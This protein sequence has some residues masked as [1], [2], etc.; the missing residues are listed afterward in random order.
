MKLKLYRMNEIM[1]KLLKF[2]VGLA[3]VLLLVSCGPKRDIP[4]AEITKIAKEAYVYGYP[5]VASYKNLYET[6]ID[7]QGASYKG[8]LNALHFPAEIVVPDMSEKRTASVDA[9]SG[10]AWFDLRREPLVLT[11]PEI[12]EGRYFSVQLTDLFGYHYDYISSGKG[13]IKGGAYLLAGPDWK[14]EAPA[15]VVRTIRS[16]TR[17][18]HALV[19]IQ[20]LSKGEDKSR[21]KALQSGFVLQS[22][23]AFEKKPAPPELPQ[24]SFPPYSD[25]KVKTPWFFSCLNFVLQLAGPIPQSEAELFKQFAKIDVAPGK[26]FVA[27][28]LPDNEKKAFQEGVT[29]AEADLEQS[30]KVRL[31]K[32]QHGTRAELKDNFVRAY[33]AMTDLYG[34]SPQEITE[35][36]FQMD[37]DSKALSGL[38]KYT[39]RFEKDKL[40]PAN[41]FWS[42]TLYN[43]DESLFAN[44]ALQRFS[45]I[46]SEDMPKLFVD[47]NDGA[48]TLFLQKEKDTLGENLA[49]NWLPTPTG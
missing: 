22:L 1:M 3:T 10:S 24:P 29:A 27:D 17:F 47:P 40:P 30:V 44:E 48:V 4:D 42:L 28:K 11:V 7:K 36:V 23:S 49:P 5:L 21:V 39:V 41:G 9:P 38:S 18:V 8:P 14:G 46:R 33:T 25:A 35:V 32:A 34:A 16:D 19:R 13:E 31:V 45:I 43:Q 15:G 6:S 37:A 26:E 12:G 2:F 20:L